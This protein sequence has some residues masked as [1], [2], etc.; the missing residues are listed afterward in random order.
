MVFVAVYSTMSK[1]GNI[2][3]FH[4]LYC[5]NANSCHL[6]ETDIVK[7]QAITALG[8]I[9]MVLISACSTVQVQQDFDTS[10]D[11]AALKAYNWKTSCESD[12]DSK[13]G[14]LFLEDGLIGK[15]FQAAIDQNL[16]DK[17]FQLSTTPDVLVF[18]EYRELIQLVNETI[19]P[20]V[21]FGFGSWDGFGGTAITYGQGVR[22][23]QYGQLTILVYDAQSQDLIWKGK[24]AE[25][26]RHNL[27]PAQ[28]NQRAA[29]LVAEVLKQFP[30][31]Q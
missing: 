23:S 29:R 16:Q 15:R 18:C 6:K 5:K 4:R 1:R 21:G 3:Q 13:K 8:L 9:W 11:F 26:I 17:G 14:N 19:T 24:G 2:S 25:E 7:K 20:A 22:Q 27:K 10:Y 31:R 12:D 28:R 30:P